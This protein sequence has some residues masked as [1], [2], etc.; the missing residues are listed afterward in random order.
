MIWRL[1]PPRKPW[2]VF[3]LQC[4]VVL[5]VILLGGK[6]LL[7]HYSLGLVPGDIPRC[8][9]GRLY[10]IAKGQLPQRR[11]DLVAF[12]TTEQQRPYPVG[13]RFVKIVAGLPGDRVEIDA[14]CRGALYGPDYAYSFALEAPVLRRLGREC[15]DF[16][17]SYVIPE[18]YFF[19]MGTL[20]D[21]FDSRY[22]GLV[23]AA[24]VVGRAWELF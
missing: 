21:S 24:Q 7:A 5:G 1:R 3:G 4:L 16:Q 18:A 11:L 20:P 12:T 23:A 22:W 13:R 2:A 17:A 6:W 9:P 15:R 14:N 19:V 10:L 8:L